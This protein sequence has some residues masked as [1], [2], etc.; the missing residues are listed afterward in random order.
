[1][2]VRGENDEPAWTFV[3][4]NTARLNITYSPP[5]LTALKVGA[6]IQYQSRFYFEPGTV[7]VTTGEPIR[8]LQGEYALVD[9]MARYDLT[10]NISVGANLR[11]VT[12]VRY[13]TSLTFD[14]GFY[15]APRSILGTISFRY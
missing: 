13:L 3:P 7:S 2:R 1:M 5:S 11:N 4:R 15:G 12:N 9:L 10:S 6:S 8:L 14:Q